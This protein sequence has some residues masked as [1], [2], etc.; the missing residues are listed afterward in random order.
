MPVLDFMIP[1]AEFA[2]IQRTGL[3]L[4]LWAGDTVRDGRSDIQRLPGYDVYLCYGFTNG[5]SLQRNIQYMNTLLNADQ[6]YLC[7]INVHMNEQ[8]EK[9]VDLFKGKFS[10]IDSDY[11]GNTPSIPL[12]AYSDLLI[13]GGIAYHIEGINSLQIPME[14][15]LNILELFA[16]ALNA[17]SASRR[18]WTPELIQEAKDNRLTPSETWSSPDLKHPYYNDLCSK[19]KR[20]FKLQ[21]ERSPLFS[22]T[23][24]YDADKLEDYWAELPVSILTASVKNL[25]PEL[26]YLSQYLPRLYEFLLN[27]VHA[28]CP[29]LDQGDKDY[30]LYIEAVEPIP[31]RVSRCQ[32][33][34]NKRAYCA[35]IGLLPLLLPCLK[36]VVDTRYSGS[37]RREYAITIFK[38]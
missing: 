1:S 16:P 7:I 2:E 28:E 10:V 20:F 37:P 4:M 19:Q 26:A 18:L 25:P 24:T 35:N 30:M 31:E 32:N 9:F 5:L 38:I 22:R 33:V 23:W 12:Q 21:W 34:L 14:E 17:E 11:H 29:G 13:S 36:Y 6:I 3:R 8:M 15:Y 27:L